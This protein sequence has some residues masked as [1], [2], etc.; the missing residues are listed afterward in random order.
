MKM[1]RQDR[2]EVGCVTYIYILTQQVPVQKRVT[3]KLLQSK[4][5]Y[6][7]NE[8]LGKQYLNFKI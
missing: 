4:E 3:G 6:S 1:R 5:K 7:K 8:N 2:D